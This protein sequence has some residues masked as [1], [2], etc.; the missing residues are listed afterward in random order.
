MSVSTFYRQGCFVMLNE[1]INPLRFDKARI[2][3]LFLIPL[4]VALLA[5]IIMTAI[6]ESESHDTAYANDVQGSVAQ[7][8]KSD[9]TIAQEAQLWGLSSEDYKKYLKEMSEGPN[10]YWWKNIDPPQVLGMNATTPEEQMKYAK[11]D[12]QLDQERASKELS[13]QHAYSKAFNELYPG[14]LMIQENQS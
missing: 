10:S 13:F 11:I 7:P 6:H 1:L 5:V 9:E 8:A 3:S 14:A 4:I 12:V 2:I